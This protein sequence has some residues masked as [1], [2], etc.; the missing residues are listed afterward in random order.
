MHFTWSFGSPEAQFSRWLMIVSTAMAAPDGRHRVDGLDPGLQRLLHRL[1]LHHR[2]GLDLEGAG[3]LGPDLPLAVDRPAERVGDPA[4]E[5]V[6][7]GHRQDAPGL[8]DRAAL[9]DLRRVAEDHAPDL[10]LVEVQGQ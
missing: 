1:A 6:P 2:R 10:A 9:L 5:R 8:L 3:L 7:D 4:E